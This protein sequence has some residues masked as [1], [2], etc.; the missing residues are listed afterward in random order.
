MHDNFRN[1]DE[2]PATLKEKKIVLVNWMKRL[3]I[4]M[5]DLVGLRLRREQF[6]GWVKT[7]KEYQ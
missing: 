5:F 4:T 1:F 2:F 6:W 7:Q 3:A